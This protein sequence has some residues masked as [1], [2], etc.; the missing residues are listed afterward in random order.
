MIHYKDVNAHNFLVLI[1]KSKLVTFAGRNGQLSMLAGP[2]RLTFDLNFIGAVEEI[3]FR[4]WMGY[5]NQV[6]YIVAWKNLVEDPLP[7]P[8]IKPFLPRQV[9]VLA[10][11]EEDPPAKPLWLPIWKSSKEATQRRFSPL[12]PIPLTLVQLFH[13]QLR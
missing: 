5:P 9:K 13:S 6:T 10:V 1:K 11:A 2:P 12:L 7:T 8:Q 3:V 4:P